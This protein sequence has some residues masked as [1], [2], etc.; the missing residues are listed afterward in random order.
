MLFLW[1]EKIDLKEYFIFFFLSLVG[2]D[3]NYDDFF[4]AIPCLFQSLSLFPQFTHPI[5]QANIQE[6]LLSNIFNQIEDDEC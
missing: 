6:V 1:L 4:V 2:D 5:F 3:S